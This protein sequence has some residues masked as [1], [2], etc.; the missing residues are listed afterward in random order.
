MKTTR[1]AFMVTVVS[2]EDNAPDKTEIQDA[3][4][5]YFKPGIPPEDIDV[6][7]VI[8]D[9]FKVGDH[10]YITDWKAGDM[11]T[12]GTIARFEKALNEVAHVAARSLLVQL[13]QRH[14][15]EAM[16]HKERP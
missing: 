5:E 10:P 14:K 11:D 16:T 1:R 9:A 3:I 8:L 12:G 13:E 7:N 4:E 6:T 15:I 2:R